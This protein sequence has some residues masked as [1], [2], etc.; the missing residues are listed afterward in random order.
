VDT[1]T[2]SINVIRLHSADW[3]SDRDK[4]GMSTV[5]EE[6]TLPNQP[7][8][9]RPHLPQRNDTLEVLPDIPTI[10]TDKEAP[11]Q[12]TGKTLLSG[13]EA[14]QHH[15]SLDEILDTKSVTSYAVTVKDLHGK[16]VQLPPPPRAADGEK[17]FECPYCY[18]IC[19]ARYG[20]G[21]AWR[22]HLLQ[23]LQPYICTYS[24]CDS[25]EQLFRSR[26]EWAEHEASHR[27]AWRC[28]EHPAAIYKTSTGLEE[29]FRREHADS[30][31]ESQLSAIVKVGET[32][33]VDVRDHCPICS[34]PAHTDGL[35]DFHNHIANHLERIATFALPIGN[36]DESDGASSVASRGRSES[37]QS[38]N[39][40]DLSLPSDATD[41]L[42]AVPTQ[43]IVE[44]E[45]AGSVDSSKF[46]KSRCLVHTMVRIA[47]NSPTNRL[48]VD[49]HISASL[50]FSIVLAALA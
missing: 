39:M 42:E 27:K 19:P 2:A 25:S 49:S 18:I 7:A 22:T 21:R 40:S 1:K 31:P 28:P 26:R 17:D 43:G 45:R 11:S 5:Q 48:A 16:G 37:S 15:Q 14:T 33:T 12:K 24:D 10:V 50:E 6:H 29:H 47:I 36:E 46:Y 9:D 20:R 34:A 8:V 3:L 13:T 38:R 32:T 4:L 30:F 41:N 23:D 44:S 35:G